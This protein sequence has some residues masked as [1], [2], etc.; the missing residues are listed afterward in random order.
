[1]HG[2][3]IGLAFLCVGFC[4]IV[5]PG[6][7]VVRSACVHH[8]TPRTRPIRHHSPTK[9]KILARPITRNALALGSWSAIDLTCFLSSAAFVGSAARLVGQ[10]SG[11]C[12]AGLERHCQGW[13][14]PLLAVSCGAVV[15]TMH[16]T[17][18]I[19]TC[20]I[21]DRA[22]SNYCNVAMKIPRSQPRENVPGNNALLGLAV[23]PYLAPQHVLLSGLG[24][25]T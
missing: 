10:W 15:S 11:P 21:T 7:Q 13:R 9:P 16:E 8:W 14:Q 1:M 4:E 12:R 24:D 20:N 17:H 23:L 19:G 3:Q 22:R 6:I 2:G 25:S 18:V 5:P